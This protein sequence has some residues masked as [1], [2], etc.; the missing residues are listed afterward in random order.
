MGNRAAPRQ[1]FKGRQRWQPYSK[2]TGSGVKNQVL[3]HARALRRAA[4]AG[5]PAG[6]AV[7]VRRRGRGAVVA[8]RLTQ[9]PCGWTPS[10]LGGWL[11]QRPAHG[12]QG[13]RAR[14]PKC[15]VCVVEVGGA[16]CHQSTQCSR[17]ASGMCRG[18][19]GHDAALAAVPYVHG[20]CRQAAAQNK[21][22]ESEA[23][24]AQQRSILEN[25]MHATC[26]CWPCAHVNMHAC[27]Q[28]TNTTGVHA[29]R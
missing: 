28:A 15:W 11:K 22:N 6:E 20:S 9:F 3:E 25:Q 26:M 23:A 17:A 24:R 27:A 21:F 19:S 8:H 14:R 5:G 18:G 7:P 29:A 2:R 13:E 4:L 16:R 10:T 1:A 12:A